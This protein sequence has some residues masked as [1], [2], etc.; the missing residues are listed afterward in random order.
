MA[1]ALTMALAAHIGR[2]AAQKVV[3]EIC[4]QAETAGRTV[5]EIAQSDP[6]IA[7]RLRPEGLERALDPAAYLGSTDALIEKS[8]SVSASGP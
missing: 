7:D 5:K 1:E 6:R 4:R 3:A 8:R 2:P